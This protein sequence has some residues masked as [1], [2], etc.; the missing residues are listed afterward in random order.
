MNDEKNPT[1]LDESEIPVVVD[2]TLFDG[3]LLAIGHALLLH[4]VVEEILNLIFLHV[5]LNATNVQTVVL[6]NRITRR[7]GTSDKGGGDTEMGRRRNS[8]GT[9]GKQTFIYLSD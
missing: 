9:I 5:F 8:T 7:K 1:H 2:L 6:S 3:I 4:E